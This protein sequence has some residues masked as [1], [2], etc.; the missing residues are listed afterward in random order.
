MLE[1][2][3]YLLMEGLDEIAKNFRGNENIFLG[4]KPYG[5]HAGNK[6]PFVVYPML[7][8]ERMLEYGKTPRFNFFV[9][10]NDW[11]QTRFDP[12][13]TNLE[14]HP[15]NVIPQFTT[16]QFSKDPAHDVNYWESVISHSVYDV[17]RKYPDVSVRCVR[18]S[19]MRDM[20][21]MKDV[22]LKTIGRPD[23]LG[24]IMIDLG[25]NVHKNF[26][27]TFCNPICPKCFSARTSAEVIGHDDIRLKCPDCGNEGAY[28]Y[29]ILYY[30]LYHKVL[31]LPRIKTFSIDL[32]I[33]GMDHYKEKDFHSRNALYK[34]YGIDMKPTYILYAPSLYGENNMPMGKSKNNCLD[35]SV[36]TLVKMIK[37]N[38]NSMDL[39]TEWQK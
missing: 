13:L 34:A 26:P 23:L 9:F 18:N 8:C 7:L 20:I 31:A 15:F 28:N 30:W 10:I 14:K 11:E 24:D 2:K 27:Y 33:S 35:I 21:V 16:F 3:P 19:A 39:Y 1:N 5:F 38:Q 36:E 6:I 29:H 25:F 22:V 4:I 32:C 17:K 12:K 37:N